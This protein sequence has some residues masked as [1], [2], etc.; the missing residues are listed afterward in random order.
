MSVLADLVPRL[1]RT[2]RTLAV[3]LPGSRP[4]IGGI[5]SL[6]AQVTP[7]GTVHHSLSRLEHLYMSMQLPLQLSL[8]PAE[9][10]LPIARRL[11]SLDLI[12][13]APHRGS[14]SVMPLHLG[15]PGGYGWGMSGDRVEVWKVGRDVRWQPTLG[16]GREQGPI[17]TII[18][19]GTFAGM[20]G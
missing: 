9:L 6:F 16:D 11:P 13:I 17:T 12:A 18:N 5:E 14:Q 2:I 19:V 10:A 1:P 8:S 15:D 3:T 4:S 7:E 20:N